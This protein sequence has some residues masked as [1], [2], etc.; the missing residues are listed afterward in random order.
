MTRESL[1]ELLARDAQTRIG[2][3]DVDAEGFGDLRH[4]DLFELRHHEDFPALIFELVEERVEETNRFGL[5]R[6]LRGTAAPRAERIGV[7]GRTGIATARGAA[8]IAHDA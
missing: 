6:G 8:M 4:R 7:D 3:V 5:F 2:R 1:L